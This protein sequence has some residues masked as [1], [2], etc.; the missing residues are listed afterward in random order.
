MAR[1]V[2]LLKV[3]LSPADGS[4]LLNHKVLSVLYTK[5]SGKTDQNFWIDTNHQ[6][7]W[8]KLTMFAY[9]F[10]YVFFGSSHILVANQTIKTFQN[11]SSVPKTC[12]S[13]ALAV[14][15]LCKKLST[16]TGLAVINVLHRYSWQNL[17]FAQHCITC[18]LYHNYQNLASQGT[19]NITT[20]MV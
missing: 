6:T 16:A 19:N 13:T 10:V 4:E 5:D 17:T 15:T 12:H 18:H 7:L 20:N 14:L 11:K 3:L 8:Y 1:Y 9:M 2:P